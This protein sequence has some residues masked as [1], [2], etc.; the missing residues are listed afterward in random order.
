MLD[1]TP[2]TDRESCAGLSTDLET[3]ATPMLCPEDVPDLMLPTQADPGIPDIGPKVETTN[4]CSDPD[5]GLTETLVGSRSRIPLPCRG[6]R[7]HKQ[8]E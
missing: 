2:L 5:P 3:E 4:L 7:P 6:S 8:P 1:S